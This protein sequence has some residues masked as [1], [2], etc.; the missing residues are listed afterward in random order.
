MPTIQLASPTLTIAAPKG[1]GTPARLHAGKAAEAPE[2]APIDFTTSL[3]TFLDRLTPSAE[4]SPTASGR[5]DP[6][7]DGKA[8]PVAAADGDSDD[9]ALPAILAWLTPAPPTTSTTVA[10]GLA[11]ATVIS[12]L[13][14]APVILVAPTT[15]PVEPVPASGETA[16]PQVIDGPPAEPVLARKAASGAIATTPP[17]V[18]VAPAAAP[19]AVN[20]LPPAVETA[21]NRERPVA[22]PAAAPPT[23]QQA[24]AATAPQAAAQVFAAALARAVAPAR[25]DPTSPEPIAPGTPLVSASTITTV[26]I[27]AP[28]GTRQDTLDMSQPHWPRHM[29]DHIEALRDIADASETRIRL[30]PDALGTIDVSLKREGDAVRV[31]FTAEQHE[32]RTLLTEAAPKL[33]ELAEQRGIRLTQGM[34][35]SSVGTDLGNGQRRAPERP[36]PNTPSRPASA[37]TSTE[38]TR[39]EDARVA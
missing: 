35:D 4:A 17:S 12:T 9:D 6:A 39:D 20:D 7:A 15:E 32:T 11:P 30:V 10:R 21:L 18:S 19:P 22:G 1:A 13:P 33:A 36:Q 31:H 23:S 16:G 29:I 3:A 34:T 24:P 8:V 25:E 5:H 38:P 28:A 2:G 14:R 27:A 26:A 37:D